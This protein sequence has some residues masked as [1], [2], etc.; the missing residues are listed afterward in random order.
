M[1]SKI[2][3]RAGKVFFF[4]QFGI[5]HYE[6]FQDMILSDYLGKVPMAPLCAFTTNPEIFPGQLVF[7]K[8][9]RGYDVS[10]I[11]NHIKLI[12]N[13][14]DRSL[15]VYDDINRS[16]MHDPNSEGFIGYLKTM[17]QQD[18]IFGSDEAARDTIKRYSVAYRPKVKV[19]FETYGVPL[20]ANDIIRINGE[21]AR[22]IKVDHKISA[23]RKEW[24]MNVETERY[25]SV[26]PTAGSEIASST[27]SE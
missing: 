26:S 21:D 18:G 15:H 9:E 22:V 11:V 23:E 5:A 12:T 8:M 6:N 17:F 13:T 1:I 20:R 7:N 3:K 10:G 27:V 16:S 25:Q 4:D 2:A 24:M 14:T 19:S